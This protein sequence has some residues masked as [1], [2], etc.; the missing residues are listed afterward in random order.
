M[1]RGPARMPGA[2]R[3]IHGVGLDLEMPQPGG[4]RLPGSPF[5][6]QFPKHLTAPAWEQKLSSS[7][8]ES[9]ARF[10]SGNP[11]AP[12]RRSMTSC[13]AMKTIELQTLLRS[14]VAALRLP[15]DGSGW[16]HVWPAA[17]CEK[18]SLA[19]SCVQA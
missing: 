8:A 1:R 12:T 18:Q 2:L 3:L 17:A 7:A 9:M 14:R 16:A 6:A 11:Q 10:P 5:Q 4:W 19:R 15:V 13:A